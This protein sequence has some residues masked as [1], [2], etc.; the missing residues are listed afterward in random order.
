[1]AIRPLC[2]WGNPV[3]RGRA[4]PVDS[5]DDALRSL[6]ADMY[7]TM[8]AANG[9]GLA[10]PQIGISERIFVLGVP[11]SRQK[12]VDM[13]VV[14]PEIVTPSGSE[15]QE[16]GCLSVPGIYDEVRRARQLVLRGFDEHGK[17]LEIQADGYLARAIQHEVDHI[18]GVLFV[19]R[20][21]LLR[22]QLLKKELKALEEENE[23]E[24]SAPEEPTV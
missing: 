20:L 8:F 18:N 4:K 10:A 11:V 3:L 2:T 7:E 6:V 14:N 9:V 21:S 12:R 19:D 15:V 5:F 22:R 13:A 24:A 1:M 23:Q 17:P 16:E